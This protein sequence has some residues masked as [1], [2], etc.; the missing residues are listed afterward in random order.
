[1][2][3][4]P[5]FVKVVFLLTTL[6]TIYIFYKAGRQAIIPAIVVFVWCII[7]SIVGLTGFYTDTSTIPP[8]FL[9]LVGPP[10]L[11]IALL[12]FTS[13]GRS[14]LDSIDLSAI[15]ILHI[16]RIPVE[17]VLYWLFVNNAVPELMTF[18]GRNFDIFSG[19]TAPLVYYFGFVRKSLSD[20]TIITW[21]IICLALLVN[22]VTIAILSAPTSFQ[23]F[24][25]DQPNIGVF[26][27]P[28]NLLPACIVPLVLLSHLVS[29]RQLVQ[30]NIANG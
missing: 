4:L 8:R 17:M 18:E 26:F 20:R 14:Y 7:Q 13:R 24:A 12:F 19:I 1:M 28:F 3:G 30:K 21:N 5:L 10:V 16:V 11:L 6:L 2:E 25:F 23:K 27:F 22:I 9:L 15:T 29:I